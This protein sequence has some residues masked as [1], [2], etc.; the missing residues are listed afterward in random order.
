VSPTHLPGKNSIQD[1]CKPRSV[2][3]CLRWPTRV[4]HGD[5]TLCVIAPGLLGPGPRVRS[6]G[7]LGLPYTRTQLP[8]L[9]RLVRVS[10]RLSLSS[11]ATMVSLG[12]PTLRPRKRRAPLHLRHDPA[13][14]MRCWAHQGQVKYRCQ[15][16]HKWQ[17]YKL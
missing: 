13:T 10:L 14:A 8:G 4:Q 17:G 16:N 5:R 15:F 11:S 3:P 7:W 9:A 12:S 2:Q 6:G 1:G